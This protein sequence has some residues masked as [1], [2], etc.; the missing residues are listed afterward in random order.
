M[1]Y[2]ILLVLC[3]WT[4]IALAIDYHAKDSLLLQLKQT[5]IAAERINIYRNLADICFET[6]DEKTYLLNMYREAQKAGDTS[7]ML[8]ALNDLVCGETKEYRMDSAYHYMELIKA[9]REPQETAPVLAY[10]QM[11]FFD[12]LCS[13]NETEEAITKE[14]Q[15]IEEKK[16]DEASLYSKIAQAY[17]TGGSL[18]YNDMI[19]EA[20]PYLETAMNLS[21]QLPPEKQILFVS[22]IVWKLSNTYS[23]LNKCDSAIRILDENLQT[24]QQYYKDH[25]QTQRPFYNM[26][27]HELRFYTSLLTNAISEAPEKMD[28]YWQQI[29]KLNKKLTNPYDRYNYFLSMDNYYLNQK[30]Q[31]H[32]EKALV[33]NDSLIQIAQEIIPNNLPGLY[34]IQSQTYE[35]MGN[36]KEALAYLRIATQYKDSLTTENMQK[37]LGE[38]QIKYEVNKLNN[39]KSQLEIKNKRILVICLSIILII[40]IFVCL[41]LYHDLKKEK[42]MKFHLR[43]LKEANL[44]SICIQEMTLLNRSHKPDIDYRIDLPEHPI[45]L[46]THEKY[47]SLV[48]EH[49]LNNANKF[50]EKGIITLHCH[51]D[52]ARQQVHI[53]VTDTGCGIPADKHKEVFERF[54]KL[55]AFTP[56]NGLGLYLCQLIIRRL[57]GK[58][59]IDP[60]YTGGI[61]ITVILP[62]Q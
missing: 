30:P 26:A 49:L 8:N 55:N 58:I 52:E 4:G 7:G 61:R 39:E 27:I 59:S 37:Q 15:F 40:V 12:T 14:L 2:I 9:I 32:Y 41:Y 44:N 17:I 22:I 54:S 25:Y 6:P 43:N 53:S 33:A 35:A 1:R 29:V 42:K 18:H 46:T 36:F 31:P 16:S 11:R 62:V 50:T 20:L 45:I 47:L 3:A 60:T 5:T 13:H 48:I 21:K 56:G 19:K 23:M 51:I 10:L 34:D 57:S 28:Y 38:L 24:Q